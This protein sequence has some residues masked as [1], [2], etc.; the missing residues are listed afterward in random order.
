M[1]A[2][3]TIDRDISIGQT[4]HLYLVK[5]VLDNSYPTGGYTLDFPANVQMER[6]N[7]PNV[8]GY[9][10]EWIRSTQKLK[11][12]RGDNTNAA[13]APGIEVANA[14]DL[15]TVPGTIEGIGIGA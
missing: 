9:Q 8:G 15:S 14:V 2:T 13:A 7:F 6:L 12:Y 11:I 4:E 3:P 5:V 10:Y 1:A